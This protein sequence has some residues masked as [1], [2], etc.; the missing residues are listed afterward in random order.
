[1]DKGIPIPLHMEYLSD[2]IHHVHMR[3]TP[4][5]V[6]KDDRRH[7]GH[8]YCFEHGQTGDFVMHRVPK[9]YDDCGICV[10][11]NV[12]QSVRQTG[13]LNS[14]SV[15]KQITSSTSFI[16]PVG[17]GMQTER[18]SK[19]KLLKRS[20]KIP[21]SEEQIEEGQFPVEHLDEDDIFG[22]TKNK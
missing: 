10:N 4:R 3:S 1:M 22:P 11:P 21:I 12:N 5:T 18:V 15:V 7:N 13:E 17:D 6:G 9:S 16:A 8:V 14:E 20:K 19:G 2:Y